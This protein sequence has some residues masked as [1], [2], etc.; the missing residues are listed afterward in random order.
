MK[1]LLREQLI[2]IVQEYGVDILKDP[3]KVK[4]S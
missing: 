3:G 4:V 1:D 2:R